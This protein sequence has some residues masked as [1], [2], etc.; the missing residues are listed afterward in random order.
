VQK[1]K[2]AF[3]AQPRPST[4]GAAE[5]VF[6]KI[7]LSASKHGIPSGYIQN[8]NPGI[9]CEANDLINEHGAV[10]TND[11]QDP[12]LEDLNHDIN[13]I[14]SE[15]KRSI[16]HDKV[17]ASGHRLKP[18]KCWSFLQSLSGKKPHVPPNQPITFGSESQ[19]NCNTIK[20]KFICQFV[21]Q[22]R[23]D[24]LTR[25]V[26]K[27]LHCKHLLDH[28]FTPFTPPMIEKALNKSKSSTATGP[29]GLTSLHL[30]HL[31]PA[32]IS[33]HLRKK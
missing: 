9:F 11:P 22:P 6:R 18:K 24:P 26:Q 10:K 29:D 28:S 14:I 1:S 17:E 12:L 21:P 3:R 8:C 5:K 27:H 19:S 2:A 32:A 15:N 31:G 30:K 4:A 7:L 16:W 23:S 13:S 20:N 25:Q 33:Y